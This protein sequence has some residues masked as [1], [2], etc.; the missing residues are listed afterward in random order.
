MAPAP[1]HGE[2]RVARWA[3]VVCPPPAPPSPGCP[4]AAAGAV[5]G[6]KGTRRAPSS[7]HSAPLWPRARQLRAGLPAGRVF[8]RL[9]TTERVQSRFGFAIPCKRR[10]SACPQGQGW[11]KPPSAAFPGPPTRPVTL[12]GTGEGDL[13][14]SPPTASPG[15]GAL[16]RA[17]PARRGPLTQ[18]WGRGTPGCR[19]RPGFSAPWCCPVPARGSRGQR[20]SRAGG[21]GAARAGPGS[22]SRAGLARSPSPRVFQAMISARWHPAASPSLCSGYRQGQVSHGVAAAAR[23]PGPAL[24]P[25]NQARERRC[26]PGSAGGERMGA[27]PLEGLAGEELQARGKG[28]FFWMRC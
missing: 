26:S 3:A 1:A 20:P 21:S 11:G 22:G 13:R 4:R 7:G 2:G 14:A 15:R 9:F 17:A 16:P 25:L 6:P 23:V 24:L 5:P 8:Q 10:V 19:V 12:P 18:S 27:P 28:R